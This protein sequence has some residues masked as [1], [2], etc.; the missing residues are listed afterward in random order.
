MV[1]RGLPGR[2]VA[3][4]GCHGNAVRSIVWYD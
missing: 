4:R 2:E 3:A 1:P